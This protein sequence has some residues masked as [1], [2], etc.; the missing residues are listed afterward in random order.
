MA[1]FKY[2]GR[3]LTAMDDD[4]PV[5]AA[6]LGKFRNKWAWLYRILGQEG[7]NAWTLRNFFDEVFQLDLSQ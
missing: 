7:G 4:W 1:E 3:I 6:N 2:L 5:V